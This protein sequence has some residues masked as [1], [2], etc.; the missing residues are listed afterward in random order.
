M[1]WIA[2]HR[3]LLSLLLVV[4][5][6]LL[7]GGVT[8]VAGALT[9]ARA[10]PGGVSAPRDSPA[11]GGTDGDRGSGGTDDDRDAGGADGT[12]PF[13]RLITGV[14]PQDTTA[15]RITKITGNLLDFDGKLCGEEGCVRAVEE[16]E[17]GHF[18]VTLDTRPGIRGTIERRDAMLRAATIIARVTWSSGGRDLHSLTLTTAEGDMGV[19]FDLAEDLSV[20]S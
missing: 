10:R 2:R 17:T 19:T 8:V 13:R 1:A 6:V 20:H 5:V 11:A 14:T 15:E 4:F 18:V 3:T 16:W 9:D 12:D 7:A